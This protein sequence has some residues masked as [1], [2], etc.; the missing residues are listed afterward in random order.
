M[1]F[2]DRNWPLVQIEMGETFGRA[3]VDAYIGQWESY[4]ARKSSFGIVLVQ[5]SEQSSRPDKETARYYMDWCKANKGRITDYCAGIA[6]VFPATKLLLLY[7]PVTAVSTKKMYGCPGQA[8]G[9][10]GEAEVWLNK[11][12]AMKS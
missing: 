11:H 12:L 3:D 1:K 6:V 7:K 2:T 5:P 9:Q 10:V 4:L 8:F